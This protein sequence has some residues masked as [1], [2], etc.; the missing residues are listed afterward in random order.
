MSYSVLH[1]WI[2][3]ESHAAAQVLMNEGG[4]RERMKHYSGTGTTARRHSGTTAK[5]RSVERVNYDQ[6]AYRT[7]MGDATS[8]G[9]VYASAS[10]PS[11][12][13]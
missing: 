13:G 3:S 9:K 12:V 11:T 7:N 1:H 4:R 8:S 2:L 5:D 10:S 6:N